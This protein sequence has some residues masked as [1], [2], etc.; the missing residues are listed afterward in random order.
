MKKT[1]LWLLIALLS[2]SM[3]ALTFAGCEKEPEV[4]E[5]IVEKEVVKEVEVEAEGKEPIT[6]VFSTASVPNDAHTQALFEFERELEQ[7]SGYQVQVEIYHSSSL[8]T[9]TDE[10]TAC[11]DGNLDMFYAAAPWLAEFMDVMSMFTAGYLYKSYDH[12][13]SVLNGDI[14]KALFEQAAAEVGVRPLGAY[15]LGSRQI[16]LREKKDVQTPADLAG[17]KMRM[18]DSPSWLFLGEALGADPTPLA[19]SE[20]YLALQ[21]GTVDGQ[22]NPMP[23]VKNAKF[24]EV[25][26][27]I[28]LTYHVIGSVWPA[29]N[30]AKWQSLGADLQADVLAAVEAGRKVCDDTNIAAEAELVSF[31]EGE[32]MLVVNPDIDAFSSQVQD[33][34]LNSDFSATWDMDLFDEVQAMAK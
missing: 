33:A 14:G 11:I 32:G 30:E 20:L 19:F 6:L 16:N 5:K 1:L 2:M 21:T 15:Y 25:T 13:T 34:Y 24:Y 9:Q 8:F 28:S 31:F 4:V 17:V 29:I 12:M 27:T 3:I 18:P 23:T 22:D 26:E 7:S 10:P